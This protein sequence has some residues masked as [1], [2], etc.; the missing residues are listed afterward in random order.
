MNLDLFLIQNIFQEF[1]FSQNYY[2]LA[3]L[4][5]QNPIMTRNPNPTRIQENNESHSRTRNPSLTRI[6]DVAR[7]PNPTR[8]QDIIRNPYPTRIEDPLTFDGVPIAWAC[9]KKIKE[10]YL[11]SAN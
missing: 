8:I 5:D 7:N 6:Q 9:P 2:Y 3:Q 4:D 1:Y 10:A 11:F